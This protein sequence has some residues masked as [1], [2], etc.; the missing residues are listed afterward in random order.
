MAFLTATI[1]SL[2]N[3]ENPRTNVVEHIKHI[4][5][6]RELDEISTCR[7]FRQVRMQGAGND[8]HNQADRKSHV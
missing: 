4:Y 2:S 3:L 5:E 8:S 1:R 7:K 6:E